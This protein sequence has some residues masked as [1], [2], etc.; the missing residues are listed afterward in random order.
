[1]KETLLFDRINQYKRLM[2]SSLFLVVLTLCKAVGQDRQVTGKITE[3]QGASAVPGTNIIIKGTSTGTVSNADG[4]Y[5]I[6]VRDNT[7]TLVFSSVG[8][9]SQ[10][11]AVGTKSVIDV[12]LV[13]DT[14]SLN[15]VVVVGYGTQQ[16][17]DITGAISS[18]SA[19]QIE[20]VPVTTLDQALQ[21]RSPGVQVTNNDGSPGGGVSVQI[22][23][24]GTFGDNSPLY[25]VDGYPISGGIN[26]LNPSDIASME[27]LK[28]ASATA[29][30]G[31]RASNGVVIVTTKR[32]KQGALQ[33]SFDAYGSV[34]AI[35]ELY[36]VLNAQDFAS[37]ATEIADKE[38]YPV[39]PE[40]RNPSTLRNIDWQKEVYQTGYR[41]NY[42]LALRGGSDKVQT[43][44]SLGYFDQRG[45]IKFS[46]FK[47]YNGSLNLDYTPAKWIKVST[48]MKYTRTGG[49]VG[50]GSGQN[51]V[52]NLTKL[53]PTMTGNPL[54]DQV[55]DANGSYGY[56][57]KGATAVSGSTNVI[58]DLETTDRQ[59]E[60][61]NLLTT[62]YLEVTPVAGLRLKTNFGWN[63]SDGSGYYFTPTN[64]RLL[65]P[66]LAFYSQNAS[67]TAEWLWENTIAYNKTFGIHSIDFV[68]GVSAQE[69]TYRQS[70]ASGSGLISDE[71]RNV[72][73]IQTVTPYGNQQTWS[74]ASQFGRLTYKLLDRYIITGTVRRDG[75][76]RFGPGNKYGVFP[77]LSVA[78]RLKDEPFLKSVNAVSDLK[79]RGSWGKAGNQNIGL[80][81]YQGI[82]S[83][84]SSR[85]D[86]RGYVFGQTKTYYDGLVLSALPNP[87]LT[88]EN[89]TQSNIGLDASFLD[90]RINFT[91]DYYVRSSSGF[92]LNVNVPSQT[93]FSTATRNVGSIRNSGLEL[94]L[95]YR[96][97][98]HPFKWGVSANVTTVSNKILS[99]ADGLTSVGNFSDLG[100][101]TFGGNLWTTFTQS[102]VGG[103]VGA[104]YGFKSAGIFQEQDEINAFN[105]SAAAKYGPGTFYQASSTAPGDRRFVDINGDDRITDDDRVI[106][107]S[108]IPKFFGGVNFDGSYGQFDVSMFW[109][110]SVGNDILNYAKRNL[111]SL[112]TNGGVGVENVSEEFYVNR[113]TET[114]RSTTYARAVRDDKS[115][116]TRVSDAYVEDGSF[117]RLRNL[118]IGYTLPAT[119]VRKITSTRVRMYVS[120]QNLVTFTKYTGLDPEIGQVSDPNNGSTSAT[121]K[122]V[123][124]G[125][126][127]TSRFFTLGLSVQ[128]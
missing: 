24:T 107:G 2:L 13:P 82:Y 12:D 31:N 117:L 20:K 98:S 58:A 74:L 37:F 112:A 21:G 85:I 41:Q 30:Y 88:W 73:S 70:G 96:E 44:L 42:N 125:N 99:F 54:T 28:D 105:A 22:R 19:A 123:D 56:Y 25:V 36:K 109:Y 122:G 10:D 76:S 53:V 15:E 91:A 17:K 45:T 63:T 128:F 7:S 51:G 62:T 92:L 101:P 8:Y 100:F 57:T 67:N 48:S 108:P 3:S 66:P 64:D 50:F 115:G 34:Q 75:S 83:S 49:F 113:W 102:Q 60:S 86:N 81:Q 55:K 14:K 95:E 68:G 116:N 26:T 90:G 87:N 52:G 69:N 27:I 5:S 80:F 71:L 61:N 97:S 89:Q 111:Q 47:R 77:S 4:T 78:W 119:L 38:S 43:S 1:M 39:L 46:N 124:V 84:G 35:P 40:W 11:V 118:Q 16:R 59:Q 104:F 103:Q 72:G 106:I 79:L 126:Y 29:I 23:G 18:V 94:G 127:P 9:T 114:N 32:G 110:A 93:G 6:T 121:V 65:T 33:V 120:G